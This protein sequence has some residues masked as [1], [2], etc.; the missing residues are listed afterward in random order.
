MTCDM[1]LNS[2]VQPSSIGEA[3]L[4]KSKPQSI[5]LWTR[6]PRAAENAYSSVTDSGSNGIQS[7]APPNMMTIETIAAAAVAN[8]FS[9]ETSK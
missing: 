4:S 3:D 1:K 6:K 8:F 9:S 7:C 5:G 2:I